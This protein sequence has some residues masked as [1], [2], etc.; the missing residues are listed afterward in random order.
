MRAGVSAL[1]ARELR[2]PPTFAGELG[3]PADLER[4]RRYFDTA[5]KGRRSENKKA[6]R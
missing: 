1:Q 2:L 5:T 6:G 4:Q 3:G